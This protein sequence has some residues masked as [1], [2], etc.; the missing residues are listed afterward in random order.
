MADGTI[1]RMMAANE[2]AAPATGTT[3]GVVIKIF[4][5]AVIALAVVPALLIPLGLVWLPGGIG[6]GGKVLGLGSQDLGC[7]GR[8]KIDQFMKVVPN[9]N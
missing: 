3:P 8:M 5:N 7:C 6:L 1:R 9:E 4:A 2:T